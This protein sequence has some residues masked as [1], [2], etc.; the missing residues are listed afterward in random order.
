[1]KTKRLWV[2]SDKGHTDQIRAFL[3]TVSGRGSIDIDSYIASSRVAID[4][5]MKCKGL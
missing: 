1:M 5:A 3:D 2:Q 4:V